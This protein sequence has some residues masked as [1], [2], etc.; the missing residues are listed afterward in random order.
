MSTETSQSMVADVAAEKTGNPRDAVMNLLPN[1]LADLADAKNGGGPNALSVIEAAAGDFATTENGDASGTLKALANALE[2]K[3]VAEVRKL[4]A[5]AREQISFLT[6][7]PEKA[8]NKF[9][10]N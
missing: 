2:A 7:T 8:P 3:D 10:V 5:L 1:I 4:A 9:E 6:N